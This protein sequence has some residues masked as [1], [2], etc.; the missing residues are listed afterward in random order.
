VTAPHAVEAAPDNAFGA[1]LRTLRE[2][3][4]LTQE[5]LAEKAGLTSYAVSSLERGRRQ[6]PYPHTVRSLADALGIGEEQRAEL[7]RAVPRRG[8]VAPTA[9][10]P[11]RPRPALEIPAPRLAH[12]PVAATPLLGREDELAALLE[13]V[14]SAQQRLVTLTGTGGVGKTRLATAMAERLSSAF[15]DGAAVVSLAPLADP[16][17]VLPATARAV[18]CPS[19][20]GPDAERLLAEHLAPLRCLLVLDNLEHLLGAAQQVAELVAACPRLVVLVTS[21]APLR[22]RG[23]TEFPVQPLAVPRA[24]APGR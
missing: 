14:L 8:V 23:E 13:L 9:E 4:G 15:P 19:V 1:R 20:E 21:R 12:L 22:V 16:A 18:G 3:A 5:E 17:S 24:P 7:M 2:Q 6:R 11:P 10:A